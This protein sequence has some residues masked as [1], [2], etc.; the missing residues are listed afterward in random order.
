MGGY[1]DYIA[2]VSM[3]RQRQKCRCCRNTP[4][5]LAFGLTGSGDKSTEDG[6]RATAAGKL[7][8]RH[9]VTIGIHAFKRLN[10]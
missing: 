4:R 10:V 1:V 7:R 3:Y 5:S 6:T 8:Q 9:V 2:S